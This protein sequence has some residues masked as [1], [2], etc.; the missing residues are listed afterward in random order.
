MALCDCF[1]FSVINVR[2]IIQNKN[3]MERLSKE[4]ENKSKHCWSSS[5]DA[6]YLS[7][8]LSYLSSVRHINLALNGIAH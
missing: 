2:R 5:G 3:N 6:S 1:S 7:S 4:L 8:L